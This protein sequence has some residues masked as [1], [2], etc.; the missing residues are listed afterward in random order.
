MRLN[1][2]NFICT[3]C[4]NSY[5]F[6]DGTDAVVSADGAL[7]CR[8][9]GRRY[10]IN[11]G[12]PR[13]VPAETYAD[14]FGYQWNIHRR[15]QL[16]SYSGFPVSSDRLFSDSGWSSDLKGDRILEAGS[17]AGRFTEV[18]LKTGAEVFSFD[19]S[20]AV[21]A[22]Q[23]NNGHMTNLNLF[24]GDI[25]DIPLPKESFDKVMCIGVL[26]HTP[27]PELA[28]KT[29]VQY[30]KP[31]GE[32]FIDIY[33][34]DLFAWMQWK[35]I[36]RPLTK[37][38]DKAALYRLLRE[39]VPPLI[40]VTKLLGAVA[41]RAGRRLSPIV[42]YSSLGLPDGLN[43]DWAILDTFDMY[44]PAHDHPKSVDQIRRWFEECGFEGIE[45]R[46]GS[47]GVVGTG[48]KPLLCSAGGESP[49]C[50]AL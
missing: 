28:F 44:S 6:A 14:S 43:R 1:P 22:N 12:I 18:L 21:E 33:R 17:G 47:N 13:F 27:A 31:G 7:D 42:E 3:S 9:C 16:D 5:S 4:S 20:T 36:L 24:Q 48:N 19:Y 8:T 39:L 23:L 2:E 38:M 35:Y 15:T 32:I 37:R 10:P 46:K 50:A 30:V 11:K 49:G 25:F 26:Q 34:A 41:G 40:P 45:V 29:L